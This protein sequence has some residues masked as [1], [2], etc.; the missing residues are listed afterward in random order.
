MCGGGVIYKVIYNSITIA[1]QFF[2]LFYLTKWS[3]ALGT[4]GQWKFTHT[5]KQ[6]HE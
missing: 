3:M 4:F 6:T 5:H 1:L 2:Y